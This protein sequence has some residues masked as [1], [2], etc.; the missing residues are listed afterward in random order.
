MKEKTLAIIKPDAVASGYTEEIIDTIEDHGFDI[1]RM[2]KMHLT[3]DQAEKF[4]AVHKN[5]SF[6]GE[7]VTFMTSGPIVVMAL[8]K[9]NAIK[10]WRD[11]MGV[12]DPAK[13]EEGTIRK[14]FGKNIGENATHGSD[15]PEN[16]KAEV[17]F[18]FPD[19]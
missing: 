11:L 19:L 6:F 7:L 9:D 2:Q 13:A 14:K 5:R 15:S 10:T 17:V 3:K 8:E 12:T 1:L 16:A 18:F 4:Y